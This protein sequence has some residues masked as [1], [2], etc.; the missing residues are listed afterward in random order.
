MCTCRTTP[1]A[2]PRGRGGNATYDGRDDTTR[3]LSIA[4][5]VTDTFPGGTVVTPRYRED[6]VRLDGGADYSLADWIRVGVG[7]KFMDNQRV[8]RGGSCATPAS[9]IRASYRNFWPADTRFQFTGIRL[10]FPLR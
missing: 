9:H 1:W 3:P 6:R 10:A 5:I 7:G 4:Y 2:S 8:L